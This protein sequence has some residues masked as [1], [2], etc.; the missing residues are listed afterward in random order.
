MRP[1]LND[2][3]QMDT[4][5]L[6]PGAHPYLLSSLQC[7]A[8]RKVEGFR[9]DCPRLPLNASG[10][11]SKA[12][13][14]PSYYHCAA[15]P[16]QHQDERRNLRAGDSAISRRPIEL[17]TE[18]FHRPGRNERPTI[19]VYCLALSPDIHSSNGS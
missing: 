18:S 5:K 1:R 6:F 8:G 17:P 19:A 16:P 12:T 4:L 7:V 15:R 2:A 14:H 11:C 13:D 10:L 3:I 9:R